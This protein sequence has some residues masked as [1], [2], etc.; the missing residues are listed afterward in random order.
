MVELSYRSAFSRESEV[1]P[2]TAFRCGEL[3]DQ[4]F[5]MRRTSEIRYVLRSARSIVTVSTGR[6]CW[7]SP[8]CKMRP[9]T[10]VT[11]L[12]LLSVCMLEL[13]FSAAGKKR[14]I[15]EECKHDM[16]CKDC[17]EW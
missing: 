11:L 9:S 5:I 17:L 14:A 1:T 7:F 13:E 12:L 2:Q 8:R 6:G 15:Y 16:D 3:G 4:I 10:V